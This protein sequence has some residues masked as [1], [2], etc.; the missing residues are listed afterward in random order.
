MF[1]VSNTML[2]SVQVF[3]YFHSVPNWP[4]VGSVNAIFIIGES[5]S[6]LS[7]LPKIAAIE[8]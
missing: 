6:W 5:V 8:F 3:L 1:S 7:D 2:S 4:A